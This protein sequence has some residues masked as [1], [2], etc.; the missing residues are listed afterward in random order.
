MQVEKLQVLKVE[1]NTAASSPLTE[2]TKVESTSESCIQIISETITEIHA[3]TNILQKEETSSSNTQIK[4]NINNKNINNSKE[5]F[6]ELIS[7]EKIFN[8]V[9][10]ENLNLNFKSKGKYSNQVF[11]TIIKRFNNESNSNCIGSSFKFEESTGIKCDEHMNSCEYIVLQPFGR[12][13]KHEAICNEC[14]SEYLRDRKVAGITNWEGCKLYTDVIRDFSAKILEIRNGQVSLTNESS[15]L[16]SSEILYNQIIPLA[17]ELIETSEEFYAEISSKFDGASGSAA[18]N[19]ELVKIKKFIDEIPLV[20]GVKPKVYKIGDNP[21]LKGKYVKL[22]VF[23]LN[24]EGLGDEVDLRGV[25]RKL[26]EHVCRIVEL[27]SCFVLQITKWLRFVLGGFYDF[28]F[29]AEGQVSDELFRQSVK[30]EFASENSEEI[31]KLKKHYEAELLK[32]DAK[33]I[34]LEAQVSKLMQELDALKDDLTYMS[35][36]EMALEDL[37][38][39]L[40]QLESEWLQQKSTIANFTAENQMLITQSASY[41]QEL[42]SMR[43]ECD[44]MRISFE[45]KLNNVINELSSNYEAQVSSYIIEINEW[46]SK[47]SSIESRYISESKQ[48]LSERDSLSSKIQILI[49]QST[50]DVNGYK[51][52][53]S[54]HVTEINNLNINIQNIRQ[55]MLIITQ[56]RDANARTIEQLRSE[57]KGYTMNITNIT[58]QYNIIIKA[59]DEMNFT[60][61]DLTNQLNQ[62]NAKIS[63]YTSENSMLSQKIEVYINNV[64]IHTREKEELHSQMIMLRNDSDKKTAEL[65]TL[66]SIKAS[67]ENRIAQLENEIRKIAEVYQKVTLEFIQKQSV[68]SELERKLREAESRCSSLQSQIDIYLSKIQN[69]EASLAKINEE[70]KIKVSQLEMLVS[71]LREKEREHVMIISQREN[72]VQKLKTTVTTCKEEWLR[73]AESYESLLIDIKNQLSINEHLKNKIAELIRRIENHN[74][75]VSSMDSAVKQ[76]IEILTR[77]TLTKKAIDLEQD[78]NKDVLQ[79]NSNIESIRMKLSKIEAQKLYKSNFYANL[80]LN[81]IEQN[82]KNNS[83]VYNQNNIESGNLNVLTNAPNIHRSGSTVVAAGNTNSSREGASRY[84]S[85]SGF[86]FNHV[87]NESNQALFSNL[88]IKSILQRNNNNKN[89]YKV[90]TDADYHS[91]QRKNNFNSSSNAN[92]SRMAKSVVKSFINKSDFFSSDIDE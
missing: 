55:E 90:A 73:L 44:S 31:C 65:Q 50:Q 67:L 45:T 26:K 4:T 62:A 88:V 51:E 79:S 38:N 81:T 33:I 13:K 74:Q 28:V 58:N 89:D 59:R 69:T 80:N 21:E 48:L 5:V 40:L 49:Q 87:Q 8:K 66:L 9:E 72:D 75:N 32:K 3:E 20:D 37:R 68:I 92:A 71:E 22:A 52:K 57:I 78:F 91:V 82:V 84:F 43:T 2:I 64:N 7:N 54:L 53:I 25:S 63:Q 34:G 16:Q 35:D 70:Y 61:T 18:S 6:K 19:D 42:E 12:F 30:I 1:L 17:D 10:E 27:R 60:I 39:K 24:I 56:E 46:R 15:A 76:Q 86:R 29:R 47:F 85:N 11:S 14:Q 23:L 83:I 77:H 36:Q 41:L